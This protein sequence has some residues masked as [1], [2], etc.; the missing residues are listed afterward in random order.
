MG[1]RGGTHRERSYSGERGARKEE[2]K[3]DQQTG[4]AHRLDELKSFKGQ[5]YTGV[6]IGGSHHWTYD[7]GQ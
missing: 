6:A 4:R 7:S 5:R 3:I 1:R 2:A